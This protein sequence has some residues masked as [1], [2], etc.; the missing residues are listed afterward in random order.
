MILPTGKTSKVG[1]IYS[2]WVHFLKFETIFFCH[3][4]YKSKNNYTISYLCTEKKFAMIIKITCEN[5][6]LMDILN[7][8]PDTDFGLYVKPLKNGQIA[9]NIVNKHYYE[10]VFQDEKNSYLPEESNQIDYQSYCTPLAVLHICNELFA[11]ILKSRDEFMQKKINWLQHTQGELD[12]V[13][14]R[15]EIP[16]FYIDSNWYRGGRFLL[17]K[18]FEG[19][20]VEKQSSRIFSLTITASTIFEAFNLLCLV[21]LFT[22]TTNDYGL[23]TYIDDNLAQKYGRVLTNIQ[24][25]PYFVFYLFLMR[26]VKSENQFRDLK[27]VF[28]KY[29]N[30]EGLKVNLEWQGTKFQRIRF[31][32]KQLELDVPIL[33]IGCGEFDY[34]KRMMKLGFKAQYYAVDND[35]RIETL[36]RNVAK[37]YEENN[38][39]FFNSLDEF[40]AQEKLNVLL[41]EVIEHNSMDDAKKLIVQALAYPVNKLIITT[42]NVE[43]NQFF[44]MESP[45]RHDDHIFEANSADFRAMIEECTA[46]KTCHVE[47]FHLGDCIN[48]I[49]PT[50]GCVITF[51]EV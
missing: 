26:A 24:H 9:G 8:N 23:F 49:Q 4:F 32:S 42:P 47:Y 48:G 39:V 51:H 22:H 3:F 15:I 20:V 21:S 44:N 35:E 40:R 36:S 5:D 46:G 25:V 17:T 12:T 28:E 43:F 2:F 13:P 14:C 7:K 50:Q 29:L 38:L 41:T 30:D 10:V 16:S 18:Y 31:I 45:L 6:Y 37:R 1:R 11:H 27:P 33:D 34:Y 19:I